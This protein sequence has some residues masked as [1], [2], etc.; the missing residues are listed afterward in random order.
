MGRKQKLRRERKHTK[1]LVASTTTATPV[2]TATLRAC[3]SGQC[4]HG[5]TKEA[6]LNKEY[7][8][9]L[10][11]YLELLWKTTSNEEFYKVFKD[12]KLSNIQVMVDDEFAQ[13]VFAVCTQWFLD[14]SLNLPTLYRVVYMGIDIRYHLI[15]GVVLKDE[16]DD[17]KCTRRR[18]IRSIR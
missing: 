9:A 13:I 12:F 1:A 7:Q 15:P 14:G 2:L 16:Y 3:L 6:L 8:T 17:G 10:S 5:S 18:K 11:A 4:Q